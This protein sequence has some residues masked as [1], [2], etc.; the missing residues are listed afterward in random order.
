M[1]KH[2]HWLGNDRKILYKMPIVASHSQETSHLLYIRWSFPANDSGNLARVNRNTFTINNMTQ[3]GHF[4]KPELT[5][6][7]LSIELILPQRLENHA[8]MTFMFFL[9]L[10]EN[11]NFIDKYHDKIII[12]ME[13]AIHRLHE[14]SRCIR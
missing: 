7:Q 3:I 10:G 9:R 13:H 5:L 11:E 2:G 8:Q 1:C 14:I 12:L 6:L 4:R